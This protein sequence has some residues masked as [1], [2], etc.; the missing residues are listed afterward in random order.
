VSICVV[1]GGASGIFAALRAKEVNPSATV[2][3]LEQSD[4][5]L[6][7]VLLS[8]GG[9]CNLTNGCFDPKTLS[10]NYP[11]GSKELIGPFHRFGPQDTISWFEERGVFLKTENDGRVFPV[12]NHSETIKNCLLSEADK[13]LV[14]IVLN[15]HIQGISHDGKRFQISTSGDSH[16]CDKLILATGSSPSGYELAK[17][18]GHTIITPIPSLFS[19]H[20]QNFTLSKLSGIAFDP[21]LTRIV[22]TSFAQTGSLLITHY[23]FSGPAILKLSAWAARH[24][25]ENGY[26]VQLSI[27]WLPTL[28]ADDIVQKLLFCKQQ[29]PQRLLGSENPFFLPQTLWKELALSPYVRLH[30]CSAAALRALA[31]KLHDDRYLIHGKPAN[32]QEFVTCGGV[33]SNQINWKS[34]ESKVCKNLFFAGELLNVDGVTGGFNLQNAWT[35]G[36]IAGSGE[37]FS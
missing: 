35:T 16:S 19:F 7:K 2:T 33:C 21:V 22:G 10:S 8:G 17:K 15:Q 12:S 36:Y 27:N 13:L 31:S 20:V 26:C 5:L 6:A 30:D 4:Q 29:F 32:R 25:H 1:G 14:R 18:F 34:M 9:R 37:V 11:R 23:G 28:P 3:V 24:M